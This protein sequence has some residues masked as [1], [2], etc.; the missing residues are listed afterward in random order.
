MTL[1]SKALLRTVPSYRSYERAGPGICLV[2]ECGDYAIQGTRTFSFFISRPPSTLQVIWIDPCQRLTGPI[3]VEGITELLATL[4]PL[5][6]LAVAPLQL[7]A[8]NSS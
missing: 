6:D 2:D 1:I 7:L 4:W 3:L 8:L 5:D